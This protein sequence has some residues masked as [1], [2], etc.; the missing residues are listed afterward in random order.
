MGG[1]MGNL[2]KALIGAIAVLVLLVS[3]F[4]FFTFSEDSRS[5]NYSNFQKILSNNTIGSSQS[6][7]GKFSFA[8]KN[9]VSSD[10]NTLDESNNCD[11]SDSPAVSSFESSRVIL[12]KASSAENAS[13][14]SSNPDAPVSSSETAG[15]KVPII[16]KCVLTEEQLYSFAKPKEKDMKLTCSLRQLIGC[17]LSVGEEYGVR[18]DIAFLQAIHETGWFGYSRPDNY[19]T[20]DS[21]GN[22][23]IVNEPRPEGLY[24]V[25]EDNNFCGL[26]V[27]GYL[28]SENSICRFT[29]A[30]LGVEAHIQHLYAYACTGAIPS[31]KSLIDPRF[32]YVTRGCA[33]TWTDL[34]DGKWASNASY[35]EKILALYYKADK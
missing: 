14:V 26:G 22:T 2:K 18:G 28:G 17:Y 23:I 10:D 11:S 29:T 20:K 32:K 7:S 8:L 34:G 16:G 30:A 25:P 35:G 13:V 27:T 3:L 9:N 5:K 19:K 33:P 6:S 1:E 24:V 4:S 21:S 15:E 31:G 12:N